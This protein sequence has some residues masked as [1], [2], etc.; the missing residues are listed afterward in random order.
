MRAFFRRVTREPLRW[1]CQRLQQARVSRC[2]DLF[3]FGVISMLSTLIIATALGN[4]LPTLGGCNLNALK[5]DNIELA[6]G[7]AA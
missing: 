1:L 5:A 4:V 7:T 6:K 2:C 3:N